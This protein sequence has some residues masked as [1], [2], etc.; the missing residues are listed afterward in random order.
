M[1]LQPALPSYWTQNNFSVP[2]ISLEDIAELLEGRLEGSGNGLIV[3]INTLASAG[4]DE[5]SFLANSKYKA[6]LVNT[7]A[8]LVLLADGVDAPSG[9]NVI[10]TTNPY[11]AFTRLQRHFHPEPQSAGR[12]HPTATI[13]SKAHLADDVDV[14]A[15]AIIEAGASIGAGSIIGSGCIVEKDAKIG[16]QCRLLPRSLVAHGCVLKNHVTLQAGVIIGS[17]GF[18]Y[19]WSGSEHLKIPQVGR[20]VLHDGVEVG[21]NTCIDRGAIGD[22][23]IGRGVK[24]DNLMQ[25][26]H[27]VHIG[28]YSIMAGLTAVAGSTSIGKGCQIG[29]HAAFAG[30]IQVGDGCRIAGKSGVISDL[31]AG[32]TYAG[33]PAMPHRLWFRVA[34]AMRRLPDVMKTLN[35]K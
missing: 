35:K 32:G 3:G 2:G 1:M 17:D 30:H 16:K 11:L 21:A 5:A 18:G 10:R 20:V 26:G 8:G 13:D 22:T 6:D 14:G 4:P 34:A 7:K 31:D 19:A 29:G 12:R 28:D 15:H 9:A 33:S 27:N 25:I 24:L 23:V